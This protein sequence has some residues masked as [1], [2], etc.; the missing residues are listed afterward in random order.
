MCELDQMK[1]SERREFA[2]I[3]DRTATLADPAQREWI[4][5][6]LRNLGIDS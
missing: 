2:E 4:R 6:V 1:A 5:N 3:I